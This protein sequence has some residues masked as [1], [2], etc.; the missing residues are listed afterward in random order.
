MLLR[1]G[2]KTFLFCLFFATASVVA[3][4]CDSEPAETAAPDDGGGG[5]GGGAGGTG[6]APPTTSVGG[7]GGE[8]VPCSALDP[9]LTAV[10]ND[11][12]ASESLVG[13]VMIGVSN[14]LC[15]MWVKSTGDKSLDSRAPIKIANVSR[16]LVAS[17]VM[18]LIEDG[19]LSLDDTLDT[20]MPNVP[21]AQ[22]ITVQ[23]LLDH[24]SGIFSFWSDSD[25]ISQLTGCP[26]CERTPAELVQ[27]AIDNGAQADPGDEWDSKDIDYIILGEVIASVASN[28]VETVVRDRVISPLGLE[29]TFLAGPEGSENVVIP[30]YNEAGTDVSK[31]IH[32]SIFGVGAAYI[33]TMEDTLALVRGIFAGDLLAPASLQ[34]MTTLTV[35]TTFPGVFY[36]LG[37]DIDQSDGRE[38]TGQIGGLPGFEIRAYYLESADAVAVI[39]ANNDDWATLAPLRDTFDVLEENQE[40]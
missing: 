10:L 19:S 24:T 40:L 9:A 2:R 17:T 13:G 38:L 4:S 26:G 14:P 28:P 21:N 39:F 35:T 29:D 5:Q 25:F 12:Y 22:T 1:G 16:L 6:G 37:V 11:A 30:G 36:G 7:G 8:D 34:Q 31:G 15:A 32:P 3:M 20:W 33:S 23:H 18:L 27:Y